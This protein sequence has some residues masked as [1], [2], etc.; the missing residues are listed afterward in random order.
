MNTRS[1]ER[2]RVQ[3]Q[4]RLVRFA[5][6]LMGV[7][8]VGAPSVAASSSA[9]S[10][11]APVPVLRHLD[12]PAPIVLGP[13]PA[14]PT[15][16][17]ATPATPAAPSTGLRASSTTSTFVV[18]YDAGFN[19]NPAAKAAFQYAVNQWSNVIYSPV[20]IVIDA[21]FS[22]LA[23][24]V[25]GSAGPNTAARDFSGR[26]IA[27]TYYPIA[28]AN[29]LHGSDLDPANADIGADFSS[30]FSGF[31]FGTDGNTAGKI[32][33]ASV[34]LHELGHG[35]GFLGILDVNLDGTGSRCCGL[36]FPMSYDR[37]TTSNGSS[38]AAMTNGS[39]A[40]GNA[41]QGQDLRFTGTQ[42]TFANGGT[43]PK[44]YGPSPW[45]SGSSYSHL[46]EATYPAGNVNSLMTPA[47]GA[48]EVIHAPGPITLGMFADIGWIVGTPPTLS[49]GAARI[50]EG[51]ADNRT[52]RFNVSLSKPV[53]YNVTAHYT[54]VAGTATAPDDFATKSGTVTVLAGAVASSITVNVRGDKIVEGLHKFSLRLSAPAVAVLGRGS[55]TGTISD[56]DPGTG[57]QISIG[58]A[59]IEEGNI[60]NRPLKLTVTLSTATT[61]AVT[62]D[63][64]T[65]A[66]SA[67]AGVDYTAASGTVTIPAGAT[68]GTISITV[69]PDT[70]AEGAETFPVILSNPSRGVIRVGTGTGTI[71]D[72]D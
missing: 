8:L 12:A 44:L 45:E 38:L 52:I 29:A 46:D 66:G 35:L 5:S 13:A 68:S 37:L 55:A 33:F 60:G 51:N 59:S 2:F 4:G 57:L 71:S 43:A 63:W 16:V 3:V 34:V 10:A 14:S 9:A 36:D 49:I 42:A 39:L 62:V 48:N 47:I 72:D 32:D 50:V 41:L 64:A 19:A 18:N 1:N 69:R 6:V 23:P 65:G 53:P 40:L 7:T 54:T 25:L 28:L 26:P 70:S 17:P 11:A 30:S 15:L 58:N 24:G 21:Q 61:S 27:G 67:T 56:D 31:Y 22:A 20:P